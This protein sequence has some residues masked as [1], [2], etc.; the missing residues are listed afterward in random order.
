MLGSV[1]TLFQWLEQVLCLGIRQN[2]PNLLL[3]LLI[4]FWRIFRGSGLYL[5]HHTCQGHHW[6]R[7]WNWSEQELQQQCVEAEG[8]SELILWASCFNYIYSLG[9]LGDWLILFQMLKTRLWQKSILSLVSTLS[10]P[11]HPWTRSSWR[12]TRLRSALCTALPPPPPCTAVPGCPTTP[13]GI[14]PA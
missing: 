9:D 7:N 4:K 2:K 5:Q 13:I 14:L 6:G 10:S 8:I 11:G 3:Q 1:S 12:T